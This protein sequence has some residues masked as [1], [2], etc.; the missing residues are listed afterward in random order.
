MVPIDLSGSAAIVTG[1]SQ[2]LGEAI[3]R[4]LHR[5]GAAVAINYWP[6]PQGANR[7]KAEQLAGEL[8]E[9]ALA[10][11]GDVRLAA[12]MEALVATAR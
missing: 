1:A 4:L 9:R 12:D 3:A 10:V 11:P 6:D 5:A 2:G 8:G 7:A